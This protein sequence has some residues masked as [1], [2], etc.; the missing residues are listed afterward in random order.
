[1]FTDCDASTLSTRPSAALSHVNARTASTAYATTPTQSSGSAPGRKPSAT[2]TATTTVAETRLRATLATTCPH[3][4]DGPKIGRVLKRSI[5][6]LV[7]SCATATAAVA[8]PNPRHMT[9]TPGT[10]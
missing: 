3:S 4:A 8:E 5:V 6:P 2:A 9:S 7:M 1:M 10:T